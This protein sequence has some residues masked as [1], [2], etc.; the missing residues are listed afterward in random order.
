MTPDLLVYS[1]VNLRELQ[2]DLLER[3]GITSNTLDFEVGKATRLDLSL[4]LLQRGV[5]SMQR[6][7]INRDI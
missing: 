3:L 4:S 7:K 6:R 1:L 5:C 2:Q